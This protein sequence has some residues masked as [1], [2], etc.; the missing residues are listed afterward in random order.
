MLKKQMLVTLM[1]SALALG[2][3]AQEKIEDPF[4]ATR[5]KGD[6]SISIQIGG[7]LPLFVIDNAGTPISPSNMSIG[8]AFSVQGRIS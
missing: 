3:S 8:S 2:L 1:I 5:V 7:F 6:Q 4:E